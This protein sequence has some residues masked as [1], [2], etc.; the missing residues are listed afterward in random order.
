MAQPIHVYAMAFALLYLLV[1]SIIWGLSYGINC[2]AM[3]FA[4]APAMGLLFGFI[5]AVTFCPFALH[6]SLKKLRLKFAAV[7]AVQL[8]L[9]YFFYQNAMAHLE[10]HQVALMSLGTP[11]FVGI[12]ADVF[13]RKPP[14]RRLLFALASVG[15]CSFAVGGNLQGKH[16]LRGF[17]ECQAANAFYG[18]GQ[19]LYGRM[20]RAH[21][22]AADR[23][24]L[25]WMNL[26]SLLPLWAAM[27]LLP[28]ERPPVHFAGTAEQLTILLFLGVLSGTIGN[29]LWNKGIAMADSGTVL[30]CNNFPVIF[31]L[32]FGRLLFGEGGSW[33]RQLSAA[34]VIMALLALNGNGV[35]TLEKRRRA[36]S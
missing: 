28:A 14:W 16:M 9:M 19:V 3:D 29:Y 25:F 20:K 8:G 36:T 5:G 15:A 6:N 1:T 32:F 7:G 10:S 23:S 34:A 22:D 35:K 31:G 33:F 21:G 27:V 2:R 13:E 12:F 24:A 30:I 17:I 18:L 11:I 26:G 4:T